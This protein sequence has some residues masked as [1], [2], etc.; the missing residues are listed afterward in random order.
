M[1]GKL[2]SVRKKGIIGGLWETA[3]M[4]TVVSNLLNAYSNSAAEFMHLSI[5]CSRRG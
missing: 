4:A 5:A 1:N 2:G 3:L